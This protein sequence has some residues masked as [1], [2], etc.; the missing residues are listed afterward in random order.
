MKLTLSLPFGVV[1][2]SRATYTAQ[3]AEDAIVN[4]PV[5]FEIISDEQAHQLDNPIEFPIV[6]EN[7]ARSNREE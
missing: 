5:G 4:M 6:E 2:L 1:L 7:S 3:E